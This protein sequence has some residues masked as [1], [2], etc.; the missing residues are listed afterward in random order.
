MRERVG[1]RLLAGLLLICAFP[2]QA[3]LQ[4][5]VT[6][7]VADPI[8]IAIVPFGD[9]MGGSGAI[10]DVV[11]ADL[12]RSGRFRALPRSAMIETPSQASEVDAAD[13]RMLK[14]DY[15]LVGRW[16]ALPGGGREIR[17]E[18]VNVLTGQRALGEVLPVQGTR[19]RWAAHRIA[20]AVHQR[21]LGIGG[22]FAS[23][24]AY[25]VAEGSGRAARYRLEVADS[26]GND[27]RV[28]LRSSMPIMSPTWSPDG[29]R[30]AYVSFESG[31][32]AIYIQDL[33]TGQ[34]SRVSARSGI[35]GSPAF[36]P[37]GRRL[38]VTLSRRDGNVDVYV[39][40]LADQSLQR[41]T[42][43]SAIDTEPAFSPDGRMIYFTSDRGGRPQV[44][45]VSVTGGPAE[46]VTFDGA[47]NARPR[48]SPDGRHLATVTLEGGRYRIGWLDLERGNRALLTPGSE[49]ESPS[50][51]P[52]GATL[53]YASKDGRRGVLETVSTD[54][55]VRQRLAVGGGDLREPAWSPTLK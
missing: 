55:A 49:D 1:G 8:A 34:R 38:A 21:L 28:V 4:V 44:Y 23:R 31:L 22:A 3:Q 43:S 12:E 15:V 19:W 30:L 2:A 50:I 46:R 27:P 45:R 32:S 9:P 17:Y 29:A 14:V 7:G 48:V 10:A 11:T 6:R 42:D 18:L 26:D 36:S 53:I 39:L 25:V 16:N 20:D 33:A 13:W 40:N 54:G 41:L 5:Q 51:A 47:Y 52:N 24:V 35:N 37:D